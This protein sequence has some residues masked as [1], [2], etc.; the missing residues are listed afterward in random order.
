MKAKW[1]TALHYSIYFITC[2]VLTF[3]TALISAVLVFIGWNW[4][5]AS[6][7]E[8]GLGEIGYWQA[9]GVSIALSMIRYTLCKLQYNMETG[10]CER[11]S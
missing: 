10:E 6:I 9:Y 7:P 1:F 8:F 2:Y 3:A 11:V 5:L 4:G